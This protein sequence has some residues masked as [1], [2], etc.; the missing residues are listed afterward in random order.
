VNVDDTLIQLRVIVAQAI[1]GPIAVLCGR[2][3][4]RATVELFI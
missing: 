3:R 4:A 2:L 1:H